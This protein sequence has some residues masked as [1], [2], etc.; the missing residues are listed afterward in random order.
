MFGGVY[1]CLINVN[2]S[3]TM[4]IPIIDMTDMVDISEMMLIQLQ[5]QIRQSYNL[6]QGMESTVTLCYFK[7]SLKLEFEVIKL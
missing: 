4:T 7:S 6:Y 1:V 3:S 5:S 2:E